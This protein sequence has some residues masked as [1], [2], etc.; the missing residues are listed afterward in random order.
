[1]PC[2][3]A[4]CSSPSPPPRRLPLLRRL[5]PA[6]SWVNRSL[7]FL[8]AA[9]GGDDPGATLAGRVLEKDATL[10]L[11]VR[12]RALLAAGGLNV[13][14][15][16]E[17]DA[18]PPADNTPAPAPAAVPTPDQRAGAANHAHPLACI[19]LHATA[20]GAGVHL[21][22]SALAPP[23]PTAEPSSTA[24]ISWDT[25]QTASLPQSQRLAGEIA[26]A[27]S[28]AGLPMH[29]SA[30]S[31]RPIDSLTCPAIAIELAPVNGATA[32]DLGYQQR[33]AQA[34]STALLF[35]RGQAEPLP[36]SPGGPQP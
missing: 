13:L 23:D 9:H 2:S 29:R 14:M 6:A 34:V 26:T 15:A 21:V 16:R 24:A 10:A 33:V 32:A 11:A 12:L 22:T 5:R 8:D 4:A 7:V 30:A 1:M 17:P 3:S 36:A 28:R 27:I 35:W 19:L 25:A 31:V 18:P 20:A